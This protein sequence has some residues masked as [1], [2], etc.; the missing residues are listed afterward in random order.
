MATGDGLL[1]R[2]LPIGTI[3]LAAFVKLCAAAREHGNGIVE[4]TARG[5][6]Q[7]RGLSAASAPYFAAAVT[8][9]GIATQDGVPVVTNALTGLDPEEIFDAGALA[10]DLRGAL[11][12]G[13][14]GARL[15]PKISIAVDGGGA[16]NLDALSADVR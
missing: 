6:I 4:I 12:R 10:A 9:L 8:A 14:L 7:V 15:A 3:P 16:L 11:A 5:S 13:D 1:V 2:M